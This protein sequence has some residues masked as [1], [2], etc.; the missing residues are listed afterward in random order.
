M[1]AAMGLLI[2]LTMVLGILAFLG[3]AACM[4]VFIVRKST[5][6]AGGTG[7]LVASIILMVVGLLLCLIPLA[8]MLIGGRAVF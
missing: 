4:I 7:L 1:V 5:G 2:L 3:G 6:R 8:L